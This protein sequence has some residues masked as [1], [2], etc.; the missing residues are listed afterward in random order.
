VKQKN[1]WGYLDRK[2]SLSITPRYLEAGD[3]IG[4]V[5]VVK[6]KE[7]YA[8]INVSG[9]EIYSSLSPIQR[10]STHYFLEA[11]ET[12]Q[13]LLNRYGAT[14]VEDLEKTTELPDGRL[15]IYLKTGEIKL[16]N[17]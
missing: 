17:D 2:L 14:L 4:T 15:L 5:A 6:G 9:E 13:K 12:G 11:S 10:L 8:L 7:K 1:K 16:I 3:F